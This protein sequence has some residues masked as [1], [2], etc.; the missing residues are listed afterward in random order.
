MP[1]LSGPG[2]KE[3]ASIIRE[4][5]LFGRSGTFHLL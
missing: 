4:G 5:E 3:L 2:S 1:T